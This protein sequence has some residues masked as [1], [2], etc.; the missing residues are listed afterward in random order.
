MLWFFQ[1]KNFFRVDPSEFWEIGM[2]Y[3]EGGRIMG[4][5]GWIPVTFF[6][7]M[8]EGLDAIAEQCSLIRKEGIKTIEIGHHG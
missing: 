7:R 3:G 6:A 5:T 4:P 8:T 2:F 1:P